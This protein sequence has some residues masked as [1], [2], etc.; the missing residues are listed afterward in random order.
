MNEGVEG[1]DA[2]ARIGEKDWNRDSG[3]KHKWLAFEA[4][5]KWAEEGQISTE[6]ENERA[7]EK[8]TRRGWERY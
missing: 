4:L 8:E 5:R 2:V 7:G 3:E 1:R 6:E